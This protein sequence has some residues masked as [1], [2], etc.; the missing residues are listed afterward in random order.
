MTSKKPAGEVRNEEILL[1]TNK[2]VYSA[3]DRF[4][5]S[6][7]WS[8]SQLADIALRKYLSDNFIDVAGTPSLVG[9]QRRKHASR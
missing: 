9:E 8:L 3:A 7:E 2:H 1:R 4:A 5:K 6:K